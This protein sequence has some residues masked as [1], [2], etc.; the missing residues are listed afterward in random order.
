[1]TCSGPEEHSN[2]PGT[3]SSFTLGA[4]HCVLVWSYP[5]FNYVV[6]VAYKFC[7]I[8]NSN[9]L[10][11]L[12]NQTWSVKE[13]LKNPGF[14]AIFKSSSSMTAQ[15]ARCPCFVVEINQIELSALICLIE[16]LRGN[17]NNVNVGCCSS[18]K[19]VHSDLRF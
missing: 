9:Y 1:M 2:R 14:R 4:D 18:R 15:S 6:L 19:H 10:H 5:L 3:L 8:K 17:V 13:K 11:R 16:K 7:R 12:Q